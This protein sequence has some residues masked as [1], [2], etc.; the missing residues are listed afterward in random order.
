MSTIALGPGGPVRH[1]G[2]LRRVR[3]G[4]GRVVRPRLDLRAGPVRPG[5]DERVGAHRW[6]C[7]PSGSTGLV[8]PGDC[9][10]V[11]GGRRTDTP[12]S[13]LPTGV[14]RADLPPLPRAAAVER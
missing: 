1:R 10:A 7:H 13:R 11:S 14:T 6:P 9:R 8:V 5:G 2:L 12:T 3:P 4:A